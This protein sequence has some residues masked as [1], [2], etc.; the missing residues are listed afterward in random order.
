LTPPAGFSKWIRANPPKYGDEQAERDGDHG[1]FYHNAKA[2][3]MLYNPMS[4]PSRITNQNE[5]ILEILSNAFK[6]GTVDIKN[7]VLVML[8]STRGGSSFPYNRGQTFTGPSLSL[9]TDGN[10][11]TM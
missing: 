10:M 3:G 5:E 2:N 7:I 1:N 8:E 6:E 11:Q 9:M 4:D